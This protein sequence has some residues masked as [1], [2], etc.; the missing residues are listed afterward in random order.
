MPVRSYLCLA[1]GTGRPEGTLSE[2]DPG[3][4]WR[5]AVADHVTV[6]TWSAIDLRT[7]E[8]QWDTNS[9]AFYVTVDAPQAVLDTIETNVAPLIEVRPNTPKAVILA[10]IGTEGQTEPFDTPEGFLKRVHAVRR[11]RDKAERGK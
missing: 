5:P 11:A 1:V 9:G 4:S 8:E 6:G 2:F 3:D 7:H 10:R